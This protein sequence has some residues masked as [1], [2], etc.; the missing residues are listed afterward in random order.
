MTPEGHPARSDLWTNCRPTQGRCAHEENAR[1]F[2]KAR[3]C[4]LSTERPDIYTQPCV[5]LVHSLDTPSLHRRLGPY[6]NL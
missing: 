6:I 3:T 5:Y 1:V 2:I 4:V